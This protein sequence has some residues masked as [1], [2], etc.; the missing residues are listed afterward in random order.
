MHE[1][2]IDTN[3]ADE[4]VEDAVFLIT[5]TGCRVF[6]NPDAWKR[7]S[8]L[9]LRWPH[10]SLWKTSEETFA[11]AELAE[12]YKVHSFTKMMKHVRRLRVPLSAGPG[13]DQERAAREVEK[14]PIVQSYAVEGGAGAGGFLTMKVPARDAVPALEAAFGCLDASAVEALLRRHLP[15]FLRA[16]E[17]V[18]RQLDA[19]E[20]PARAALSEAQLGES[21]LSH[22]AYALAPGADPDAARHGGPWPRVVAGLRT[23][24]EA[25][26]TSEAVTLGEAGGA[27]GAALHVVLEGCEA[28]GPLRCSRTFFLRAGHLATPHPAALHASDEEKLVED[29][30]EGAVAEGRASYRSEDA[31]MLVGLYAALVAASRAA[32]RSYAAPGP[33]FASPEALRAAAL[34]AFD[35]RA[36]AG[37]AAG[38]FRLPPWGGEPWSAGQRL[39]LTVESRDAQ[40]RLV[41]PEGPRGGAPTLRH[42]RVVRAA[43]HG[44]ESLEAPGAPL[45][46]TEHVPR[47]A[48]WPTPGPEALAAR[49]ARRALD[50][51]ARAARCPLGRHLRAVEGVELLVP[52]APGAAAARGVLHAFEEGLAFAGP[53]GCLAL[54]FADHAAAVRVYEPAEEAYALLV[55]D[56]RPELLP[57][58]PAAPVL[59]APRPDGTFSF[60]LALAPSLPQRR[61]L[62]RDAL[63][64]WRPR[65]H[66]AGLHSE[67]VAEAPAAYA[68]AYAGLAQAGAPLSEAALEA[69]LRARQLADAF[70]PLA[71]AP[72]PLPR[73]PAPTR[74][75]IP[76]TILTGVPGSGKTGLG[77]LL[78]KL[79]SGE[80]RWVTAQA[81]LEEGVAF[82]AR[83][84]EER[85]LRVAASAAA[86]RSDP[87]PFRVLYVTSG[88]TELV[89]VAR[90]LHRVPALLERFYVAAVTCCVNVAGMR[91][92]SGRLM[93]GL[94]EQCTEGFCQSVVL[95]HCEA[96][97]EA[98]VKEAQALVRACNPWAVVQ[99]AR[100]VS[101]RVAALPPDVAPLL[102]LDAF[103]EPGNA[104]RRMLASPDWDGPGHVAGPADPHLAC[105]YVAFRPPLDPDAL[106]AALD[107]YGRGPD[108]AVAPGRPR[109]PTASP[110]G[111]RPAPG[112]AGG[113]DRGLPRQVPHNQ[114]FEI[115]GGGRQPIRIKPAVQGSAAAVVMTTKGRE[116]PAS[117]IF[118]IGRHIERAALVD[119]L[120]RSRPP[121]PAWRAP[122]TRASVTPAEMDAIR[123]AHLGE[124]LPADW[125][126]TGSAYVG[127]DGR[128]TPFHPDM[129]RFVAAFLARENEAAER[130]NE[131]CRRAAEAQE[132]EAAAAAIDPSEILHD[133]RERG[134]ARVLHEPHPHVPLPSHSGPLPPIADRDDA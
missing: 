80:A 9:A 67:S 78:V 21:L 28:D 38:A 65:W 127:F 2:I 73:D 15:P 111:R 45:V 133:W 43:L 79:S 100:T 129:E 46:L 53:R 72:P 5:R 121:P 113:D 3:V 63:V 128:S 36:R 104:L 118:V 132:H 82:D 22:F 40:G 8:A 56:A 134:G 44:L 76:V 86:P 96:A 60:A 12:D 130:A 64:Q 108:P 114:V 99:R 109:P 4:N 19:E 71:R 92:R 42:A 57:H 91:R 112:R 51:A 16:W 105:V 27:L 37:A 17:G 117:R 106:R 54:R 52:G 35:E 25:A 61:F 89:E 20:A 75:R 95:T 84:L 48:L 7:I 11:D 6:C 85:L 116:E 31:A 122:R 66:A 94:L 115:D 119:L 107:A 55:L 93:P 97:S 26:R 30:E 34:A 32:V 62:L 41:P 18:V 125:Y 124:A 103:L 58:G 68:R 87:R 102:S 33:G 126:F 123:A 120:L 74:G 90:V 24:D 70:A 131:A 39:R 98:E 88:Y 1:L 81:A 69:F 47:T 50:G 101:G 23:E 77:Q 14:W 110:T 10:L 29:E 13:S 83:A 49:A 59:L